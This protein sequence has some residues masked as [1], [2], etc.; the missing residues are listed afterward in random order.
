MRLR[1][2]GGGDGVLCSNFDFATLILTMEELRD[3]SVVG[4]S[5]QVSLSRR[6]EVLLWKR[7]KFMK[8]RISWRVC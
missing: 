2:R 6:I 4:A 1:F 3:W 5:G 7:F 8:V